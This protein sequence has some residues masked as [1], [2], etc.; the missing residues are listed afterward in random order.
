MI[1]RRNNSTEKR[2][3]VMVLALVR[4]SS[5]TIFC[6][7][8][9]TLLCGVE[10][11]AVAADWQ[12][13]PQVELGALANDNYRLNLPPQKE[14]VFGLETDVQAQLRAVSDLTDFR[15]TPELR[16]TY[17]PSSRKNDETD[18]FLNI[19]W[20]QKGQLLNEDL[21]MQFSEV[22]VVQNFA[23]GGTGGTV[24]N[25]GSGP[26]VAPG[27]L[28]NPTTGESGY[29]NVENRQKTVN[30]IPSLDFAYSPHLHLQVTA[31]YADVKFNQNILGNSVGFRSE[32]GSVGLAED[33]TPQ[34][35]LALRAIFSNNQ[36]ATTGG[37]TLSGA[38]SY[39]GVG[40]WTR[41]LSQIS[42]AYVRVGDEVTRFGA[43]SVY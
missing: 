42:Q 25:V 34:D 26:G 15:F 20:N 7:L 22:S 11:D 36:P 23:P 12:F 19:T 1:C 43:S 24:G 30:V 41:H 35:S 14:S 10:G 37:G 27:G 6:A 16:A 38:H 18:P 17:F 28:G 4:G 2:I 13:L 29:I 3:M 31:N 8:A 9:A 21:F 39:G 33:L 32:G 5:P 40:E